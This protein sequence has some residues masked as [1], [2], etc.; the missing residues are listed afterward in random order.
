MSLPEAQ[1]K[2]VDSVV[3]IQDLVE[4]IV[5]RVR[6]SLIFVDLDGVN[7]SR[8]GSVAIMQVL[9]P[10]NPTVHVIDMNL[11]QDKGF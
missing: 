9:V 4:D 6:K 5:S 11:L 2:I 3:L 8:D 1:N 7:L 10:P